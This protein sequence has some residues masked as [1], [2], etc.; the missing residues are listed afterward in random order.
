MCAKNNEGRHVRGTWEPTPSSA[1]QGWNI[2]SKDM[3]NVVLGCDPKYTQIFK[4]PQN[5]NKSFTKGIHAVERQVPHVEFHM[6]P[7]PRPQAAPSDSSGKRG[8]EDRQHAD[9]RCRA[10]ATCTQPA[11]TGHAARV[12][13]T[14]CD[15]RTLPPWSP[16]REASA[17]HR[18]RLK[19]PLRGNAP[20]LHPGRHKPGKV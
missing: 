4:R 16:S 3:H 19:G 20:Q 14:A 15:G 9:A 5:M 2:G 17:R 7:T 18:F 10:S 13:P 1:G 12:L 11:V 8:A 6:T